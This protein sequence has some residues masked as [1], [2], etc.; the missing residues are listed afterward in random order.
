[1]N[2]GMNREMSGI[3]RIDTDE[4]GQHRA[5][6]PV[7]PIYMPGLRIKMKWKGNEPLCIIDVITIRISIRWFAQ[8]IPLLEGLVFGLE[9]YH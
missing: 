8:L 9:N 5:V 7:R 4:Y 3:Q 2:C 6:M 1:M